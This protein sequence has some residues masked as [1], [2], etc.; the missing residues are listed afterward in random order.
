VFQTNESAVRVTTENWWEGDHEEKIKAARR[1]ATW[2]GRRQFVH[3]H[4][5]GGDCH[6]ECVIV[7]PAANEWGRH[8]TV[9]LYDEARKWCEGCPVGGDPSPGDRQNEPAAPSSDSHT[10]G[11]TNPA[12]TS[13]SS[14]SPSY[15]EWLG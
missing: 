7:F 15:L 9:H 4:A 14:Y 2:S 11:T 10:P 1:R 6:D 3:G 13:R 12:S 5:R 8:N